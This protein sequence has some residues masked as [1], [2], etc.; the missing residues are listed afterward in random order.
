MEIELFIR[1]RKEIY[2][3]LMEFI[4]TADDNVIEFLKNDLKKLEIL[5]NK[6]EM[7][8]ILQ[9]IS[10]ISDN[11]HRYPNL[12]NKLLQIIQFLVQ[13]TQSEISSFEIYQIFKNNKCFL[14]QLFEQGVIQPDSNII[15]DI[16]ISRDSNKFPYK[17][18]LYSGIKSFIDESQQKSIESEIKHNYDE[19]IEKFEEKCR[20][21][22]N[23][24][25][26]C[27]L[28]RQDSVEEFITYINRTMTPLSSH[29][30]PSIFE[31]NL[32][33]IGKKPTLIEYASFFGSIQIIRYLKYSKVNLIDKLWLYGVHSNNAEL[34]HF[35][36]ENGNKLK[37]KNQIVKTDGEPN[38]HQTNVRKTLHKND[39]SITYEGIYKESIICHHNEIADYIKNNFLY[40]KL[41]CI[42][43]LLNCFNYNF[44]PNDIG[45]IISKTRKTNDISVSQLCFSIKQITIPLSVT[46]IGDYALSDCSS[47]TKITIPSSVITI[48]DYA[49]KNCSSLVQISISSSVTSIGNYAF[50]GCSSLKI[51]NIPSSVALIGWGAFYNCSSLTHFSIPSSV[52]IIEWGTF[53][54]CSSLTH[55]DVPSVTSIGNFA[56]SECTSL[57]E[58][59]IPSS[60]TSI[61][62]SAFSGCKSL[63]QISIPSSV[64]SIGSSVFD[65]C[66]SLKK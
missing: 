33:L 15:S 55:V 20:I 8:F 18:Y 24:S 48:G 21:G 26:I 3:S 28:I 61:G 23:D 49:F 52:K 4:G 63:K 34:I 10:K 27:S 9:L 25:Y 60:V 50:V 16:M 29:I 41:N 65:G 44:I 37:E 32:F 51:I 13:E 43:I 14:L 1:K 30:Q 59:L 66:S 5:K 54:K 22:E 64:T 45:H 38:N 2:S 19:E 53:N 47:L 35:L 11:H 46:S 57:E 40:E 58:I 6:E 42:S 62:N 36:E 17:H 7:V 39:Q 31:S 56:F 12:L